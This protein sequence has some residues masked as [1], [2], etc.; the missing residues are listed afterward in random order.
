MFR[1]NIL[2]AAA[3]RHGDTE[4]LDL[5]A[6]RHKNFQVSQVLKRVKIHYDMLS[7]LT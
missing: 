2:Y 1:N 7:I 5:V 3:T 4:G 6:G